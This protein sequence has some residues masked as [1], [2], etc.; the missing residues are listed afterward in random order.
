MYLFMYYV[1]L[2]I[3]TQ[4]KAVAEHESPKTQERSS[5]TNLTVPDHVILKKLHDEMRK[6]SEASAEVRIYNM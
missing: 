5:A 2:Y 3:Y 1:P 4:R 6:L